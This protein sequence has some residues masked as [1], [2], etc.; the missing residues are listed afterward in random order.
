MGWKH[1]NKPAG[2]VGRGPGWGGPA[3][4]ASSSRITQGDPDGIQAMSNTPEVR[5]AGEALRAYIK[6]HML[7]LLDKQ[8][9]LAK[10]HDPLAL[11]ATQALLNR[12][13]P[14][15]SRQDVTSKGEQIGSYVIAAP[16]E[17]ESSAAWQARQPPR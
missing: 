3:R 6:P 13:D 1:L 11:Q 10:G 5:Q 14:P 8:L 4:G 15:Q 16:E 12:I 9:E 2:G 7:V 17:D